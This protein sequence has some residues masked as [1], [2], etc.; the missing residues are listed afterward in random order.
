LLA[1]VVLGRYTIQ[2][3]GHVLFFEI[4]QG[5]THLLK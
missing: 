3:A 5:F 2:K 1:D 4:P